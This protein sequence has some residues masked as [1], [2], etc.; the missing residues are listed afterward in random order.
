[1]EASK[2]PSDQVSA[3]IQE[4]DS[5]LAEVVQAVR[6]A[7]LSAGKEI[8]EQ[9]KWNSSSFYYTGEMKIFDPKTYQR[10]IAVVNIRKG[11]VLLVLPTGAT[12]HDTTGVLEGNYADGRRL[13]SI[14]DMTDFKTKKKA[15]TQVIKAWLELV[16][17]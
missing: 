17:K 4:L 2:S 15:L 13:I 5:S 1:M 9:I 7:I 11:F 6:E 8:G 10:D 14:K 16:E 12:I 3:Y